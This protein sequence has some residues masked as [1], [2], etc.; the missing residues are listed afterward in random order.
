MHTSATDH[1]SQHEF[2][3]DDWD[4]VDEEIETDELEVDLDEEGAARRRRRLLTRSRAA[5]AARPSG[6]SGGAT[7]GMLWRSRRPVSCALRTIAGIAARRMAVR[8]L[9]AP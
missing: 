5:S 1:V 7:V 3:E 9:E 2:D 6:R 8:G 4:D